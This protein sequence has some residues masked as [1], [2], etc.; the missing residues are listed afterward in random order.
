VLAALFQLGVFNSNNFAPKAPPGA[1]QVFRPNGPG[2][3]SFINLEGECQGELPE[4]VARFP[5][6]TNQPPGYINITNFQNLETTLTNSF[7]ISAWFKSRGWEQTHM[8]GIFGN[9]GSIPGSGSGPGF[10]LAENYYDYYPVLIIDGNWIYT[11]AIP[12]PATHV[13]HNLI[14]E[15]NS[16]TGAVKLYLDNILIVSNTISSNLPIVAKPY[17]I[18]NDA[19][20]AASGFDIF[21]GTLANIQVYNISLSKSEINALYLEGIGGAPIDL[22]HLVGWWPLDG[23]ANDYSG[24]GNNGVPTNVVFVS[25]WWSGYTLP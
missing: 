24:N 12:I 18:G 9:E 11:T 23:N 7:T 13:W 8:Q 6:T 16:T 19:W 20:Q 5:D 1:C 17:V 22:Q 21:N 4:Y 10:Q 2:T 25:N 3:T 14:G 15:Y